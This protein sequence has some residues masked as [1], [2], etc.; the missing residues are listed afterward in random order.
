MDEELV[1]LSD[2]EVDPEAITSVH[3]LPALG[4]DAME[5][6]ARI[7][8]VVNA[9]PGS[10]EELTNSLG[11]KNTLLVDGSNFTPEHL[12][13]QIQVLK[14]TADGKPVR[15][16]FR[17]LGALREAH[18]WPIQEIMKHRGVNSLWFVDDGTGDIPLNI[19]HKV[20]MEAEMVD[21]ATLLDAVAFGW[22]AK[23]PY[24]GEPVT[25]EAFGGL[26]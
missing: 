12:H 6:M 9:R 17:N 19:D 3:A 24:N 18:C 23:N 1:D 7:F 21:S 22:G 13:S 14:D 16:V 26:I 4:L 8:H 11:V 15:V 10:G 25:P 2:M 20:L 5:R